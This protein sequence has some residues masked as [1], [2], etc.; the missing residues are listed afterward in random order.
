MSNHTECLPI[1]G[2]RRVEII[3]Y[4]DY[5]LSISFIATIKAAQHHSQMK[6]I[7]DFY[8]GDLSNNSEIVMKMLPSFRAVNFCGVVV[9]F[10]A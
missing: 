8:D 5:V 10:G 2:L 6:I 4:Y 3:T 7:Y 9:S 1:L